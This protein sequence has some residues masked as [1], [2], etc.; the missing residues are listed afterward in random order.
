MTSLHCSAV[1]VFKFDENNVC[2]RH[3]TRATVI[4]VSSKKWGY[5]RAKKCHGWRYTKVKKLIC[6]PAKNVDLIDPGNWTQKPTLDNFSSEPKYNSLV[7][8]PGE[9]DTVAGKTANF[10][11]EK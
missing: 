4:M 3:N 10:N 1:Y 9:G 11:D 5:L 7:N 2:N 6:K 8:F